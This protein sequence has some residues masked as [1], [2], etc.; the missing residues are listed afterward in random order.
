MLKKRK[1]YDILNKNGIERG[2][3]MK[4]PKN[5]SVI[6]SIVSALF[7]IIAIITFA[8]GNGNSL[9]FMWLSLGSTF[10]CLGT[11]L[12]RKNRETEEQPENKENE[13]NSEEDK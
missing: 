7:N 11:Y 4:K 1:R 6:F 10:L 8:S 9:G 2:K 5:I 13:N 3:K 12:S